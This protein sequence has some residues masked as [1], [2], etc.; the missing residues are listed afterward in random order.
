MISTAAI[1]GGIAFVIGT[2][3]GVG[4]G[5]YKRKKSGKA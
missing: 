2:A 4:K 3:I 5:A 1:I